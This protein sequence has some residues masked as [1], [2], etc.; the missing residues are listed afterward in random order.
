MK[1]NFPFYEVI[2][3]CFVLFLQL[4]GL[5]FLL[6][7]LWFGLCVFLVVV[8][9]ILLPYKHLKAE[10]GKV[11]LKQQKDVSFGC[12]NA[13]CKPPYQAARSENS[14]TTQRFQ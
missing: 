12:A 4:A 10:D 13:I 11:I 7:L 8:M 9:T 2:G 14:N 6:L 5:V 1:T 3:F